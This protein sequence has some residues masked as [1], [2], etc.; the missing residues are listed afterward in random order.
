MKIRVKTVRKKNIAAPV[1]T[2]YVHAQ[3]R[4]L[5]QDA[6][7]EFV[8][9]TVE[10]LGKYRNKPGTSPY[11]NPTPMVNTGMTISVLYPLAA[12]TEKGVKVGLGKVVQSYAVSY[13]RD[14][15][16]SFPKRVIGQDR[17]RKRR[18]GRQAGKSYTLNFGTPE[19]L[20]VEFEVD[21]DQIALLVPQVKLHDHL[22]DSFTVGLKAMRSYFS[23]NLKQYIK[24]KDL[25][26]YL[27]LG[28]LPNAR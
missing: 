8:L 3:L 11:G 10:E 6:I 1:L 22:S 20:R 12:H 19:N 18:E 28:R 24:N 27:K 7:K 25:I 16:S 26:N 15:A 9:A 4:K 13:T 14:A 5:W 2:N 17:V 23:K 21:L